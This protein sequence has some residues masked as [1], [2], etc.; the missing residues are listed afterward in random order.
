MVE[1][2]N[3]ITSR[4]PYTAFKFALKIAEVLVGVEKVAEVARGILYTPHKK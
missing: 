1:D 4:G 3:I 2:S